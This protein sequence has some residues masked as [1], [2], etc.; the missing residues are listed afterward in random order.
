MTDLGNMQIATEPTVEVWFKTFKISMSE[1]ISIYDAIYIATSL[2][3]DAELVTSDKRLVE[4]LSQNM[5]QR[6]TLL[7]EISL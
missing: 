2:T 5:K 1:K 4:E 3:L 7:E 6:I